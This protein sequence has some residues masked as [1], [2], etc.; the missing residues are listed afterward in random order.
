MSNERTVD[1]IAGTGDDVCPIGG[2]KTDEA[3]ARIP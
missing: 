2:W 3:N 1:G